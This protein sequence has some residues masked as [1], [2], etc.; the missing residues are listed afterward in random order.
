LDKA[1]DQP[2]FGR[3]PLLL[4]GFPVM[5]IFLLW[6]GFSFFLDQADTDSPRR[7]GM[8]AFGIYAFMAAYSPSEV[9]SA[10]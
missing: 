8:I 2:R 5:M 6:T 7:V 9:S 1:A 4:F 3:R 10:L